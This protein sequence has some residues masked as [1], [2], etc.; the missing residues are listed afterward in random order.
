MVKALEPRIEVAKYDYKGDRS[1]T[2]SH[3][4]YN[5]RPLD[6]KEAGEVLKHI[7]QLWSH[8]VRLNSVDESNKIVSTV[9]IPPLPKAEPKRQR[10]Y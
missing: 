9:A 6:E 4:I 7:Y 10:T 1:L 8:P 3:T 2:L 5:R